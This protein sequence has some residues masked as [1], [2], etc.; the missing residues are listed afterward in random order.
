MIAVGSPTGGLIVA[1]SQSLG[2]N[3][4]LATE[5]PEKVKMD[6]KTARWIAT[7]REKERQNKINDSIEELKQMVC[8]EMKKA[9][10]AVVLR[11]VIVRL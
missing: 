1:L 11:Y 6:K 9:T 10:R 3:K 2:I 8:P 5:S 7:Q 4:V